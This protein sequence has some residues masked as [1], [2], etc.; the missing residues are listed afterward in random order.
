MLKETLQAVSDAENEAS[1]LCNEAY[2]KA[3]SLKNSALKQAAQIENDAKEKAKNLRESAIS[4]ISKKSKIYEA[5]ANAE[6]ELTVKKLTACAT[7]NKGK[8]MDLLI[9]TALGGKD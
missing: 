3:E 8:V 4:D 6:A 1:D 7:Q 2:K 9:Q 5:E